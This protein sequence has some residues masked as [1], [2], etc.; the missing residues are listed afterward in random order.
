MK[1]DVAAIIP[2]AGTGKRFGGSVP[3]TFVP[4]HGQPLLLHALKVFERHPAIGW[5]VVVAGAD[6]QIRVRAL[7]ARAKVTKAVSPCVGGAS[8]AASVMRG[9]AAVPPQAAW[10]LVHDAARP[11]VT[12]RL[13]TRA[14]QSA[15]RH[16]AVAC[17]LPAALTIKAVDDRQRVRLTLDRE[18]LWCMQTPQVF[19]RS[20]FA[21]A[22]AR[23][24]GRPLEPWP[25]DAAVLEAAGFPVRVILGDPLNL[26]VTTRE[27]L[28][29]AEAILGNRGL[30]SEV[31]GRRSAI[32][33]R[34]SEV[35]TNS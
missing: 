2:A 21:Q 12:D 22:L 11:C 20:W 31:R 26:K 5:I 15:R 32:R 13:I 1:A 17:G 23:L 18:Q 8:R 27:D 9:F 19:S 33:K 4:L 28:M 35:S 6:D 24:D 16:G 25:D 14:I 3:K 10:V 34:R 30:R 29:L 7:L